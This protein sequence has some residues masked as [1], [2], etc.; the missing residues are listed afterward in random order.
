[1]RCPYCRKEVR[2]GASNC[3]GC[4]AQISYGCRVPVSGCAL[5]IVIAFLAGSGMIALFVGK[6][7]S[8]EPTISNQTVATIGALAAF[9]GL[10][11]AFAMSKIAKRFVSFSR[12]R[13][14]LWR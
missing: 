1:M 5:N 4:Q 7:P 13:S 3:P 9:I 10:G 2:W 11:A 12:K 8:G 6:D 14:D